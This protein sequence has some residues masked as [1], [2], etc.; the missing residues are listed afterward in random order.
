MRK[1][2]KHML[3]NVRR[4][5]EQRSGVQTTN[6]RPVGGGS[7]GN[8]GDNRRRRRADISS[9]RTSSSESADVSEAVTDQV[10][11]EHL[12][13][14]MRE[15][16]AMRNKEKLRDLLRRCQVPGA[17]GTDTTTEIKTQQA[18]LHLLHLAYVRT[19]GICAGTVLQICMSTC[20]LFAEY[21]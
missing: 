16:R 14:V 17:S 8:N 10:F 5:R 1:F 2:V 6:G 18:E 4:N 20:M 7:V 9:S 12:L 19:F 15:R 13:L 11:G 3:G 21:A